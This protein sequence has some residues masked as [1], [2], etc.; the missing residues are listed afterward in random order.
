MLFFGDS[1]LACGV[2]SLQL[3]LSLRAGHFWQSIDPDLAPPTVE[4]GEGEALRPGYHLTAEAGWMN[5]PNGMFELNNITHV[6]Y[7]VQDP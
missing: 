7:Q 6:F 5:D 3:S 2:K 4:G 1:G